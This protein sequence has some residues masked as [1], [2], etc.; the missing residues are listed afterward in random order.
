MPQQTGTYG[1]IY[2]AASPEAVAAFDRVVTG[3]V[4]FLRDAGDRLKVALETDPRMPM[5][6]VVKGYFMK[7]MGN[8]AS[9]KRAKA[10]L[11]DAQRIVE[12]DGANDRER[13]HLRALE[14]WCAEDIAAA[15]DTWERILLDWPRDLFAL[16]LAHFKHFYAGDGRKMRDS[17]AR[18][19][20]AWEAGDEHRGFVLGMYAFGC[21]ETGDYRRAERVGREAVLLNPRD[22]WSVHAVAHV[23]EMEGRHAEGIAWVK[24]LESD[25]STTNNFR[26]H[27]HWHRALYHLER[28]ETDEV[29][30]L[31]DSEIADEVEKDFYLEICNCAA[32]LWRLEMYG[33]DVGDR[34]E[35]IA[36]QSITH[37][38][39]HELVFVTLHYLMALIGGGYTRQAADM[40]DRF[41]AYSQLDTT[42][43]GV[44]RAIG[45][46]TGE[47]MAALRVGDHAAV[48]EKL[49]PV[50]YE[51]IRMG[52]SHAQRDVWEEMLVEAVLKA[53]R[54][55]M[56]RALLAERTT[57][58][59][60]SAWSW[61]KYAE[62]LAAAGDAGGA[63]S[64]S[65]RADGLLAVA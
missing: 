43:A 60:T 22:A 53:G 45:L 51:M 32:L 5:A 56:A 15:T 55:E 10:A 40:L 25:W 1:L 48:V 57:A 52:G 46:A 63:D 64:A 65:R 21:E 14:R 38:D 37:V 35:A 24:G 33:V 44:A 39:D 54:P 61:R 41:R 47:A 59:P 20:P 8:D 62:A 7:L 18:V 26:Y 19:L 4:A 17:I 9:A 13:L 27:L 28:Y 49:W 36:R 50:R 42:Q 29:L 3:Y 30:R 34:W 31:Y 6:H 12:E 23:M 16:R 2:S 11:R 58:R